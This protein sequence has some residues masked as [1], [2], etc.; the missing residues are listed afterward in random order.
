MKKIILMFAVFTALFAMNTEAKYNP[1]PEYVPHWK[2]KAYNEFIRL[3]KDQ[4][5]K[6][7]IEEFSAK[8]NKK[9]TREE[10]KIIR[11]AKKK[12]TY[13]TP[14]QQ[15]QTMDTKDQGFITLDQ[16]LPFVEKMEKDDRGKGRY[17]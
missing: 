12:G 2:R 6:L 1:P 10:Q 16:F 4:D 3:D 11:S 15:F 17:Y 7:S 9:M 14:E 8:H 13:Q 5:G